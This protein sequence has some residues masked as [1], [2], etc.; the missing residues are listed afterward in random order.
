MLG[1][2][3]MPLRLPV[4]EAGIGERGVL[5]LAIAGDKQGPSEFGA[6]PPLL[7]LSLATEEGVEDKFGIAPVKLAAGLMQEVPKGTLLA[8][9]IMFGTKTWLAEDA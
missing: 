4:A 9:E 2:E 8:F 3:F 1:G 5:L 7:T 6:A